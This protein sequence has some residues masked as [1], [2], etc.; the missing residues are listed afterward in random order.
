MEP[1]E[2]LEQRH[3]PCLVDL[4]VASSLAYFV[5]ISHLFGRCSVGIMCLSLN[6]EGLGVDRDAEGRWYLVWV[7]YSQEAD[8]GA[9]GRKGQKGLGGARWR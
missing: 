8:A 1:L 2:I 6:K 7:R 3:A 5:E 9:S 4:C